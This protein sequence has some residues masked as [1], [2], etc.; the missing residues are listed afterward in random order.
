MAPPV[1]KDFTAGAPRTPSGSLFEQVRRAA[2]AKGRAE[3]RAFV[4]EGQRVLERA[5]RA[6]W[7]PR[8][9]LL[10][11]SLE[12]DSELAALLGRW[13]ALQ[14]LVQRVPDAAL[15]ELAEG[16]RSGL[17]TALFDLPDPLTIATLLSRRP[18]P[19]V[20]LVV[21]DVDEPGNVGALI[22]TALACDAAGA[23]CIGS[24]DPFH[25]KAVRTSLGSLFKLPLARVPPDELLPA[26]R[27]AG[28]YTL[29]A[30]AREGE[31]LHQAAWPRGSS[32]LLVGN[33]SR[34]LDLRWREGADA[35]VSIDLCRAADSFCVNAA[36]AICLY[37]VQ[38]RLIS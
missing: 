20:F 32:A 30:V 2:T 33:E 23:I 37:E 34:G 27:A 26:L 29:A 11:Q 36:A 9:L 14:P 19:A 35:R 3:A 12:R 17:V 18:P 13:P 10:G 22:R 4:A 8:A 7:L 31:A 5:L 1:S 24:T 38:R 15:L 25:P 21:V 16:R 28:V 6:G